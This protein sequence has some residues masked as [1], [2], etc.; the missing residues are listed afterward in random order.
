MMSP[1]RSSL[2]YLRNSSVSRHLLQNANL[3]MK[4]APQAAAWRDGKRQ[5]STSE[6][7]TA[8]GDANSWPG[9][10]KGGSGR[11]EQDVGLKERHGCNSIEGAAMPLALWPRPTPIP[12]GQ[13]TASPAEAPVARLS[14]EEAKGS[15]RTEQGHDGSLAPHS[16][17]HPEPQVLM[18]GLPPGRRRG[19]SSPG[20]LKGPRGKIYRY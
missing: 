9:P 12:L 7:F 18:T 11:S 5:G 13:L 8:E 16:E 2:S 6:S 14:Q 15:R 3:A 17:P 19:T 4:L 1:L 10:W 20:K